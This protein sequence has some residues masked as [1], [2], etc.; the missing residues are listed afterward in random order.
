MNLGNYATV[1]ELSRLLTQLPE[2]FKSIDAGV[3]AVAPFEL[4]SVLA[5]EFDLAKFQI[6]GNV[7][8]QHDADARQFILARSARA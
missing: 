8:R 4:K 6:V 5:D 2:I 3:M 1:P 7:D